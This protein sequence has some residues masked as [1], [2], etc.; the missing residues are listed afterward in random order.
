MPAKRPVRRT[1]KQQAAA[2]QTEINKQ[3]AAY[4]WL[5]AL[6]TNITAIGQ[7]KQL[8]RR[9]SIQAEGQKLIDI[10]NALQALAN[11]AQS[12]LTLEQG[13]TAS[14]NL[15]ALGN[16]LQAIGNSIQIIA[17]NES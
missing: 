9:K 1:A 14:N 15:N 12:A 11:T 3:L 13:N 7:T 17:S 2:L 10:G 6:G 5:Q 8:S 16:L 4:A